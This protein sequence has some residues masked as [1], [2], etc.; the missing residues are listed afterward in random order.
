MLEVERAVFKE[1]KFYQKRFNTFDIKLIMDEVFYYTIGIYSLL[2]CIIGSIGNIFNIFIILNT[3]LKYTNT[4][5]FLAFLG[6]TDL[7][8]LYFWNMDHFLWPFFQI[9]RQNESL[10]WCRFDTYLQFTILQSSAFLLVKVF[11]VLLN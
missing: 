8:S 11:F 2:L 1:K 5:I 4:F 7:F 10:F 9:D 3:N 6:F